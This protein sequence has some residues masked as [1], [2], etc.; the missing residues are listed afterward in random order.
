MVPRRKNPI[1]TVLPPPTTFCAS[2]TN[3]C[4]KPASHGCEGPGHWRFWPHLRLGETTA[5]PP[6]SPSSESDTVPHAR[7]ENPLALGIKSSVPPTCRNHLEVRRHLPKRGFKHHWCF[8]FSLSW[9]IFCLK[10]GKEKGGTDSTCQ[11]FVWDN[12]FEERSEY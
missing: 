11:V 1:V 5:G 2:C 12:T 10:T 6:A 4:S 7:P 8:H 9:I 3:I